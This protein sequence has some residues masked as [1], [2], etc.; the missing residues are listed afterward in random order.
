LA[1]VY[2]AVTNPRSVWVD[3]TNIYF[4]LTLWTDQY[5]SSAPY[6]SLYVSVLP[7]VFLCAHMASKKGGLFG[8]NLLRPLLKLKFQRLVRR[9]G[10]VRNMVHMGQIA[11]L[12]HCA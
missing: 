8:G 4:M 6:S 3:E 11:V 9:R 2:A 7:S 10:V 5:G 12:A 1:S